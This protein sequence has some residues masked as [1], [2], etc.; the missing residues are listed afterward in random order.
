M[1]TDDESMSAVFEVQSPTAAPNPIASAPPGES[2]ATKSAREFRENREAFL[3]AKKVNLSSQES[4]APSESVGVASVG[5]K[6]TLEKE[7]GEGIVTKLITEPEALSTHFLIPY[8]DWQDQRAGGSRSPK[9]TKHLDEF[10]LLCP[11]NTLEHTNIVVCSYAHGGGCP[12]KKAVFKFIPGNGGTDSFRKHSSTHSSKP[13]AICSIL[14]NSTKACIAVGAAHA[15]VIDHLPYNFACQKGMLAYGDALF[16]AGQMSAMHETYDIDN[17]APTGPT[18]TK[19]VAALAD[20]A[21]KQFV[22]E[23]LS[24]MQA[25]GGGACTDGL[26]NKKTGRKFYD[27]TVCYFTIVKGTVQDSR[28]RV[29][30]QSRILVLEEHFGAEDHERIKSTLSKALL[31]G[32]GIDLVQFLKQFTLVTDRASTLPCVAGASAS[33]NKVA[34][35]EKWSP[36]NCHH[37]DTVMKK[38]LE[39]AAQSECPFLRRIA[40]DLSNAKILVRIFK[41]GEL[42]KA[43][44]DGFKL[45]QEVD[46]RF[47]TTHT[48]AS[49][50][51]KSISPLLDIVRTSDNVPAQATLDRILIQFEEDDDQAESATAVNAIVIVFNSIVSAQKRLEVGTT[52]T[53]FYVLPF[54]E[55]IR[56]ELAVISA[57]EL[58]YDPYA[59]ALAGLT[60]ENICAMQPHPYQAAAVIIVPSMRKLEFISDVSRRESLLTMG[61]KQL[62]K[63]MA[64]SVARQEKIA[65][66]GATGSSSSTCAN[67]GDS[68][69]LTKMGRRNAHGKRPVSSLFS[70]SSMTDASNAPAPSSVDELE[71]YL[72]DSA[73]VVE[74]TTHYDVDDPCAAAN[75]WLNRKS[76]FPELYAAAMRILPTPASSTPSERAFSTVALEQTPQR[77]GTNGENIGNSVV[78]GS[79]LSNGVV[80]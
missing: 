38:T 34:F 71:R 53:L 75:F 12:L 28:D 25:L 19:A 78:A 24:A 47:S 31:D 39:S 21:R 59:R 69:S 22:R 26:K 61:K 49:R 57:P 5:P 29:V 70:L 27:F 9:A 46:T 52:P 4:S 2:F 80:L 42:Q 67:P 51:I 32:Y 66:S 45:L 74:F 54:L 20:K 79:A 77:S 43:L 73:M 64:S 65:K 60:L 7:E 36:C 44:D 8:K 23:E 1:S 63:L 50:F 35:G 41:Q 17:S 18:V 30:M 37:L 33:N 6:C 48:L 72:R 10:H 68:A 16:K 62:R 13:R 3:A 76:T 11:V 58:N 14:P 15:S 55:G 40:M 56:V